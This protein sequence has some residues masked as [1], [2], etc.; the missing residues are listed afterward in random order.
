MISNRRSLSS[1]KI[2]LTVAEYRKMTGDQKS[3]DEEAKRNID[4]IS[5]FA[6]LV[7]DAAKEKIRREN[8][9][10]DSPKGFHLDEK[11]YSCTICGAGASQENS[12][13]D[14]YGL[15]CM[16]C[17]K[18]ID[19]RIIPG[20]VATK[21]ECCY[22]KTELEIYFNI[23]R[24]LLNRYIK[25]G[26][27]KDRIIL[28]AEKKQHLQLFLI[29]DNRNFLPPKS[30]LRLRRVKVMKDGQE[31][32]TSEHWYEFID[33][34]LAKE[35]SKYKIVECFKETFSQPIKSCRLYHKGLNPL[36][37]YKN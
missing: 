8:M 14:K 16:T 4:S 5:V 22:L 12:W 7:F 13:Y 21:R 10:A 19:K 23:K 31:Y 36:F 1:K 30:L 33:E 6:R 29:K 28:N 11:G 9:L 25:Q 20:T 2:T 15:K 34:K 18:A 37:T 26:L 17:Q 32:Y 27:L 35:L 3:T 24:P